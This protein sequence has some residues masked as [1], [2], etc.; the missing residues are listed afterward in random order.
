MSL[1]E[2]ARA[3][4]ES[5]QRAR[6]EAEEAA[7]RAAAS[8]EN[9]RFLA[10]EAMRK[11]SQAQLAREYVTLC[12]KRDIQSFNIETPSWSQDLVVVWPLV[13]FTPKFSRYMYGESLVIDK[14]GTIYKYEFNPGRRA[15]GNEPKRVDYSPVWDSYIEHGAA[16]IM[17]DN[18]PMNQEEAQKVAQAFR[19]HRGPSD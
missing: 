3:A 13:L 7:A 1:E 11:D 19:W 9:Q 17:A 15:L 12:K 8:P 18:R 4:A 10:E 14:H 6:R 5:E 16:R 2:R